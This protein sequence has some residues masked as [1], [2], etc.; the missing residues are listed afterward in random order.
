MTHGQDPAAGGH[1]ISPE[2]SFFAAQEGR[3]VAIVPGWIGQ[4]FAVDA[5]HQP[6]RF[7]RV[8]GTPFI[9]KPATIANRPPSTL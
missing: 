3:K 7:R 5:Q 6:G 2:M 9:L 4:H 8:I 1:E